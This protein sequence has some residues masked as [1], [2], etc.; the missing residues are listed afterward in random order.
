[1]EFKGTKL[2]VDLCAHTPQIHFQHDQDGATLR[3]S[4]VKPKLDRFLLSKMKQKGINAEPLKI[5][6]DHDALAYKMKIER[7]GPK[8]EVDLKGYPIFYGNRSRIKKGLPPIKAVK[9]DCRL[10]ILCFH[11]V[12][13]EMIEKYLTEFFVVTNF[14]TMQGKGFGGFLPRGVQLDESEI[15]TML[16]R[17]AGAPVCYS[18]NGFKDDEAIFDGIDEFYGFMKTL[19][20]SYDP[21]YIYEYFDGK[22]INEKEYMKMAGVIRD[23]SRDIEASRKKKDQARYIKAMLGTA[24]SI[25]FKHVNTVVKIRHKPSPK[26][27]GLIQRVNSPIFFKV[28]NNQIFIVAQRIPDELYGQKFSFSSSNGNSVTI[29]TLQKDEFCID[30]FLDSYVSWYNEDPLGEK[31]KKKEVNK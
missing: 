9:A 29:P 13:R 25:F 14:G 10:T 15:C 27:I 5:S 7:I 19:I 6:K 16:A 3:A 23:R 20:G 18:W 31:V 12:L 8:H 22:F 30:D 24:G 28:I 1:M 26:G 2:E 4:E 21:P 11:P 17:D